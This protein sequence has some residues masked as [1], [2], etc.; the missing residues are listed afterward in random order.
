MWIPGRIAELRR[1]QLL[2]FLGEHVLEDLGLRVHAIPWHSEALDQI[3]L[4][5]TVMAHDLQRHPSSAVGQR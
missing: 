5:Q 3:Q 1:D 4:E 2:E